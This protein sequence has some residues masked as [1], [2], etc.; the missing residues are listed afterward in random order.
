MAIPLPAGAL[1]GA[2]GAAGG[3]AAQLKGALAAGGGI[4][5]TGMGLAPGLGFSAAPGMA[6]SLSMAPAA[7]A[8][9]APAVANAPAAA[10]VPTNAPAPAPAQPSFTSTNAPAPTANY[11]S[12]PPHLSGTGGASGTGTGSGDYGSTPTPGAPAPSGGT[13][14]AYGGD[15]AGTAAGSAVPS[16]G[17]IIQGPSQQEPAPVDIDPITLAGANINPYTEGTGGANALSRDLQRGVFG[18][19]FSEQPFTPAP[20]NPPARQPGEESPSYNPPMNPPPA[21]VDTRSRVDMAPPGGMPYSAPG[22]LD[23]GTSYA[24]AA[25][26]PISRPTAT[27]TP[28]NQPSAN[29]GPFPGNININPFPTVTA[30]PTPA[31]PP[32]PT[33]VVESPGTYHIPGYLERGG[34]NVLPQPPPPT[35]LRPS[36][37][38]PPVAPKG[39]FEG[40]P[41]PNPFSNLPGDPFGGP[42]PEEIGGAMAPGGIAPNTPPGFLEAGGA[43]YGGLPRPPQPRPDPGVLF[44]GNVP[45]PNPNTSGQPYVPVP[46]GYNPY[47]EDFVPG[48]PRPRPEIGINPF[49]IGHR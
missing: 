47:G 46:H 38:S 5:P 25:P 16:M 35:G 2:A 10:N 7:A 3:L 34:A 36:T 12:P 14:T 32:T 18:Q 28:E 33:P 31:T 23:R 44:P 9:A 43:A 22:F 1:A 37:I 17:N 24:P 29:A 26:A 4:L 21:S 11:N 15:A 20:S 39:D 19:G 40:P 41:A 42:G 49:G 27:P 30:T 6:S 48:L 8:P 45:R 13:Q